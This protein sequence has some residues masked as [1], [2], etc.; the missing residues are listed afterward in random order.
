[1]SFDR[2]IR[3]LDKEGIERYGNVEG[4]IPASELEGKT[5]QLVSGSIESGFKVLDEKTE[6]AK[7]SYQLPCTTRYLC[8]SV[9]VSITQHAHHHLR[10]SQLQ[11]SCQGDKGKY[12]LD[13]Q[14]A[15]LTG[16]IVSAA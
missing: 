7:V 4:E 6:L 15:M 14:R 5:V 2:L 1:M 16:M 3:F 10:G 13:C 11:V 12:T 8:L 9:T